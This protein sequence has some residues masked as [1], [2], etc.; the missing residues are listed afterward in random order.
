MS[1][2]NVDEVFEMAEQMEIDGAAYYRRAAQHVKNMEAVSMF[3]SLALM[4]DQHVK[5]F[6][7][8][9]SKVQ[10]NPPVNVDPDGEAANYIRSLVEG[11]VFSKDEDFWVTLSEKESMEQIL[12]LAIGKEKDSILFYLGLKDLV[13][14]EWG[15]EEMDHIIDEE[16]NHVTV[17]SRILASLK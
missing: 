13:P 1:Q 14:A 4:E 7:D 8:L 10:S 16:K 3:T 11:R 6:T 17:L 15:K 2:L 5:T 9:R 12:K